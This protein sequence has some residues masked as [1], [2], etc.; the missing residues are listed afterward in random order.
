MLKIIWTDEYLKYNFGPGHPFWVE[1][2][3]M[4]LDK[5][6]QERKFDYQ[7]LSPQK[8]TDQDILLAHTQDYLNRVKKLALN[9]GALSLD[10]P[11]N[12]EVLQAAYWYVGGTILALEQVLKGN[13]VMNLLGGLHHAGSNNSAGFCVFNDC[14]IAIKKL[15]KI[16]RVKKVFVLDIDVHAG[17][18]TQ[19]IFYE[20]PT[21]FTVSLHQDP[22]TLYPGTGF[23]DEIGAGPG[24]GFNRNF[25]LA[26]G[27]TGKEYL[28]KFREAL[29]LISKF[30][31]DLLILVFGA[32]TFKED[33]LA[34]INLELDDY[35]KIGQ[36]L[37]PFQPFA[38]LC[39]GGYSKKVPEI[40]LKFLQELMF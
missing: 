17:N 34:N 40:W 6:K 3:Q 22:R 27:T 15:Q 38:I 39:A 29:K 26:P 4:F 9:Q 7:V 13:L 37:K 23:E 36:S 12:E 5:I 28:E 18:G 33:P 31:P 32:D 24:K 10:T 2:G 35:F 8:A 14:A 21:V 1:R 19:E 20:D 16:Q 25:I 30:K 11:L